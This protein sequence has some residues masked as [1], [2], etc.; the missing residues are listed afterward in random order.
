MRITVKQ[1]RQLIRETVEDMHP[2]R[3]KELA[4][5]EKVEGTLTPAKVARK[6]LKKLNNQE[7]PYDDRYDE[8]Y[9][10][11]LQGA[12]DMDGGEFNVRHFLNLR[13]EWEAAAEGGSAKAMKKAAAAEEEMREMLMSVIPPRR[14][15]KW[16]R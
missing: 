5:V 6:L 16:D 11:I 3:R 13:S 10:K 14:P 7:S 15:A 9:F 4:H 8:T 2:A 12:E 1:L